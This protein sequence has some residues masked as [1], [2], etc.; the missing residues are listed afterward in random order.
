MS[1]DSKAV[2]DEVGEWEKALGGSNK[3]ISIL[4]DTERVIRE[5]IKLKMKKAIKDL[6]PIAAQAKLIKEKRE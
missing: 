4:E 2:F 5:V 1:D 3:I 6:E